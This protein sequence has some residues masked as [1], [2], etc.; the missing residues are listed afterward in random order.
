MTRRTTTALTTT[1]AAGEIVSRKPLPDPIGWD[2]SAPIP[3]DVGGEQFDV[4]LTDWARLERDRHFRDADKA[5]RSVIDEAV[6]MLAELHRYG[7]VHDG[8]ISRQAHVA[9]QLVEAVEAGVRA[10]VIY[11][12]AVNMAAAEAQN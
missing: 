9:K 3:V 6:E 11:E 10:R 4:Q 5:L 1:T 12:M 8:L 2:D 7:G